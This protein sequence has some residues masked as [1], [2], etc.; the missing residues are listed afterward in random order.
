MLPL[1]QATVVWLVHSD[2]PHVIR[3]VDAA[4][5]AL[6]TVDAALHVLRTV[7][8]APTQISPRA[9]TLARTFL[10]GCIQSV[11]TDTATTC[12]V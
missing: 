3:T 9:L 11:V 7:D 4:L 5:H 12:V 2:V 1:L 8:A 6:R 10:F